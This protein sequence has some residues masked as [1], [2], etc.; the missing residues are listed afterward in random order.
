VETER[1][2]AVDTD[3]RGFA[4]S[5]TQVTGRLRARAGAITPG[6]W[7]RMALLAAFLAFYVW[8]AASSIPIRFDHGADGQ[9]GRQADALLHGRA[10]LGDAP[11]G[12]VAL[13][14]P[15]DPIANA[16]YR[17]GAHTGF[18]LHDLILYQGRI[19]SYWGPT[20]ALILFAPARV[21]GFEFSETLATA[22]F[23]FAGLLFSVLLLLTLI[24]R[25]A[26]STPG[27]LINAGVV[28]LGLANAVP[29]TIRRPVV[30][31]VA[32]TAGFC[33]A[34]AGAWLVVSG[35]LRPRPS[36]RRLALGSLALGLAV[37]ARPTHVVTAAVL[38]VL[39]LWAGRAVPRDSR[40]RLLVALL[41]P[42]GACAVL[43]A[44]YNVMRFGSPADFGLKHQLAGMDVTKRASPSLS[45]LLPGLYFFV[46]A[47]ARVLLTF[48]FVTL[49]PPPRPPFHV[50]ASY[51]GTEPTGGVLFLA[52][53]ILILLAVP[54]LRLR[55]R[56][57]GQ[58]AVVAGAFALMGALLILIASVT[59][60]G[61][62][63]RYEVDFTALL[64]VPALA[65]WLSVRAG[66][67]PRRTRRLA[68]GGGLVLVAWGSLFGLALSFTG[69]NTPLRY[70]HPGVWN[71]L[72]TTLSPV[73]RAIAAVTGGPRIS[74]V[75]A[76]RGVNRRDPNY[77]T[78]GDENTDFFMDKRPVTV[79]ILMPVGG[80]VTLGATV[81]RGPGAPAADPLQLVAAVDG[82]QRASAP[83][84]DGPVKLSVHLGGGVHD[85]TLFPRL[86]GRATRPE[87]AL[88]QHLKIVNR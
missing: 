41:A 23:G 35:V 14:N 40:R 51:D 17:Q 49:P 81:L 31:E 57:D 29:Y 82:R 47:P 59:F 6:G 25:F 21:L 66:S 11:K 16:T 8:T 53:V 76:P 50:P 74:E 69:T 80:T 5:A 7:V 32:I 83:V 39:A 64:M 62:T 65:V 55:G 56:I 10:S 12:L 75:Q 28:V 52:P 1:E 27:W 71:D 15:Y 68:T 2:T 72:T 88:L 30:Y 67:G 63:Q 18:A 48:P 3:T 60:W 78:V 43:L 58:L 42:I 19:Y 61:T 26:P 4:V 77:V 85:V 79:S 33:F 24:R 70:T 9:L 54:W 38:V 86:T 84:Q 20:P 45:Y 34:M 44:A 13:P 46:I 73:S 37:G 36:A 87:L 22:L